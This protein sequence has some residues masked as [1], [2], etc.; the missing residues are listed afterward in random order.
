M[1]TKDIWQEVNKTYPVY[2]VS[3][4]LLTIL[5]T[6]FAILWIPVDPYP[7]GA[8]SKSAIILSLGILLS[9]T[10]SAFK[11]P[12][13]LLR[14]DILLILSPIYWLLLDLIQ[15]VYDMEQI[16][17]DGIT[18]AFV[19]ISLFVIGIW[20]STTSIPWR[21]PK[22][23]QK[24][25][26]HILSVPILFRLNLF[27]FL[28][29]IFRFAYPC[30]FNVVQM[31]HYLGADRWSAPWARGALGGWNAFLDHM[32]Y[33]G[34]LLPALTTLLWIR[35]KRFSTYVFVSICLTIFMALFLAQGGG[36]RVV[37]VIFGAAIICWILE[38]KKIS[39]IRLVI[40]SLVV[41][42]LL[43]VM[44]YML[45]FRNVGYKNI[46]EK[47]SQVVKNKHL[48][49]DDN[50]LRL[51]QIIDIVP[52]GHPYVYEKPI[53]YALIRPIPRALWPG[54]PVDSGFDLP[55]ILGKKGVSL[56]SSVIGEW[57]LSAGWVMVFFG[58][59]LYG[60]LAN[61]ACLFIIV[62][63][64]SSGAIVY[65]VTLM[66]LFAGMR[67]M[68]ELILMSYVLLAWIALS[69]FILRRSVIKTNT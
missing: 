30:Q 34:Y 28:F 57:Y 25:S 7:A 12:K 65:S 68:L 1:E 48:R 42:T 52:R 10:V 5:S 58:G 41:A 40:L 2:P 56:T 31:I 32:S 45:E 46:F 51:G 14:A 15:G 9:P 64:N 59:W 33:F 60:R 44:Q 4:I 37:G 21:P 18:S 67:S 29:G 26:T 36:R 3:G 63:P 17:V 43:L 11:N 35:T 22:N 20:I 38:V 66:A 23:L 54:K 47:N 24:A 16:S 62:R 8:L 13:S 69:S 49:V 27:F 53:L 6:F 50:F 19:A 61:L 55:F 39:F